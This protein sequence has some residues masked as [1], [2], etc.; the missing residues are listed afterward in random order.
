MLHQTKSLP[1]WNLNQLYSSKNA[2]EKD[3]RL[4][5][6][7]VDAF[8]H[9]R[10]KLESPS[11]ALIEQ[12]LY[13]M[14]QTTLVAQRIQ[15]FAQLS[16]DLNTADTKAKARMARITQLGAELANQELF[17][18]IW[19]KDLE[20]KKARKLLPR[21]R[22]HAYFLKEARKLR[23]HILLENEEKILNIKNVNGI[24]AMERIYSQITSGM[25]FSWKS[26]GKTTRVSEEP[27]RK[28]ILGEDPH[29]RKAAYD[30]LWNEYGKQNELLGEIYRS[31]VSDTWNEEMDLRKYKS[32][33]SVRNIANDLS[34][35]T[36]ET[37]LGVCEENTRVFQDYFA[38]KA[39]ELNYSNSRY[40][41]YAP[42][43][44]VKQKWKFE[45]GY[46]I[47]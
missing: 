9:Y 17:F 14:E 38:W 33:L 1:R 15:A 18:G 41:I 43:P 46:Q 12:I 21:N 5:T 40:H 39:K 10:K 13:E 47:V 45:E 8:T 27:L 22:D 3:I 24:H 35:S 4:L 28:H 2:F 30:S 20:E 34:D 16:F 26:G 19:W 44:Q 25:S 37:F 29:I 31:I 7:R 36:V 11:R 32:P 23:K 6:Q 42:L